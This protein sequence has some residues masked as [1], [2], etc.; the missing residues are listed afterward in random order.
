MQYFIQQTPGE[1]RLVTLSDIS[2]EKV[3]AQMK[4]FRVETGMVETWA[5]DERM[6]ASFSDNMKEYHFVFEEACALLRKN[7]SIF[8]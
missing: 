4:G 7:K 1:I 5:K 8:R 6:P 3:T 2:D